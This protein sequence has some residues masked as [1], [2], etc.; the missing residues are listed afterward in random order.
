MRLKVVIFYFWIIKK[1]KKEKSCHI[2][3][4]PPVLL[5]IYDFFNFFFSEKTHDSDHFLET[6]WIVIIMELL[7][8]QEQR[9]LIEND[10]LSD[11]ITSA[12]SF[13]A[14]GRDDS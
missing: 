10:A 2:Q 13:M 6:S 12:K 11:T 7:G 5:I 9:N 1:R 4:A 3:P 14:V 8:L